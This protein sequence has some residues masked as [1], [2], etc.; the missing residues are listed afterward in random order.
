M[1][2]G[3]ASLVAPALALLGAGFALSLGSELDGRAPLYAGLF[4]LVAELSYWSLDLRLAIRAERGTLLVRGLFVVLIAAA[5]VGLTAAIL[6][7]TAVPALPG[8]AA[9]EAVGVVAAAAAL[10][11]VVALARPRA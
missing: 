3:R 4:L 7:V 1:G 11:L 10:T 5:A 9:W 2:L 8:G 6:A